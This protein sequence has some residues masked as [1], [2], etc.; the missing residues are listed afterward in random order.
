MQGGVRRKNDL[1]PRY[2]GQTHS[3][4]QA[5]LTTPMKKAVVYL[6]MLVVVFVA[7]KTVLIDPQNVE[8]KYEIEGMADRAGASS[9]GSGSAGS[10]GDV[11]V[12]SGDSQN[13][14]V[15]K[16]RFNN[17]VAKQQEVKNLENEESYNKPNQGGVKGT[18]D[19]KQ[20]VGNDVKAVKQFEN[21]EHAPV[22]EQ[23]KKIND[24]APYKKT[25]KHD[26]HQKLDKKRAVDEADAASGAGGASG[27][28]DN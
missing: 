8:T 16:A 14:K 4:K 20:E 17:E 26:K 25:E 23:A 1:L 22:D 10:A 3:K 5:F 19:G 15:P 21:E 24:K 11:P 7:V 18:H 13:H 6:M 9:G 12:D 2:H 27:A 28:S